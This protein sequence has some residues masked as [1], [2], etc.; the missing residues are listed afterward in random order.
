MPGEAARAA[1]RAFIGCTV[2]G[3]K[4]T[5]PRDAQSCP[6]TKIALVPIRRIRQNLKS[7]I[8]FLNDD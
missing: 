2:V 4:Q 6:T 1:K 5:G 3:V 8:R 7:R